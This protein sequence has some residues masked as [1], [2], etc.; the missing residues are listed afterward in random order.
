MSKWEYVLQFSHDKK[1]K[2][3]SLFCSDSAFAPIANIKHHTEKNAS[4]TETSYDSDELEQN[5]EAYSW[6]VLPRSIFIDI[7]YRL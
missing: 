7:N 1:N 2:F 6:L 4:S 5:H 3:K